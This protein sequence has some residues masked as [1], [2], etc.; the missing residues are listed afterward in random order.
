MLPY[1]GKFEQIITRAQLVMMEGVM[2]LL[3]GLDELLE[4]FGQFL[5]VR[6]ELNYCTR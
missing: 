4:L 6:S 2:L 3:L 5:L 1:L